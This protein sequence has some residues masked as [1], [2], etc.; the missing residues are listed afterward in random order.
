MCV[1]SPSFLLSCQLLIKILGHGSNEKVLKD[2]LIKALMCVNVTR[3]NLGNDTNGVAV[4]DVC[5]R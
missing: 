5:Q 3:Y 1:N 4:L 2:A